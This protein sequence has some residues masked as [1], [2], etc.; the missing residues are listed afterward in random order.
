MDRIVREE[1]LN[2]PPAP[3]IRG[4]LDLAREQY[5]P[6][7]RHLIAEYLESAE[8]LGQ[9]T[10]QLHLALSQVVGNP[11]FAPEPFTSEYRQTQYESM[12]RG[13]VGVFT[14]L[15]ERLD[16]LTAPGQASAHLLFE[17]KHT[18]EGLFDA[19]RKI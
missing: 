5:S 7:A 19:F 1:L 10:A 12:M 8:R 16:L 14:L 13:M 2:E 6:M 17:L 15:N 18:I 3:H 11:S 9:R 4:L